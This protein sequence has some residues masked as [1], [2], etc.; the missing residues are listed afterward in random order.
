[1]DHDVRLPYGSASGPCI[2]QV[3]IVNPVLMCWLAL[4]GSSDRP[5]TKEQAYHQEC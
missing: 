5:I 4:H 2:V 3:S 1:M